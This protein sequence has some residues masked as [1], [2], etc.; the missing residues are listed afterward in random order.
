MHSDLDNEPFDHAFVT[1][2]IFSTLVAL[3]KLQPLDSRS[4]VSEQRTMLSA[5]E[6]D[7]LMR[8]ESTEAAY[9]VWKEQSPPFY[10][11]DHLPTARGGYMPPV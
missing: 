9:V 1:D 2:I 3:L 10:S 6:H 7:R 8:Q 4:R 5:D 11:V